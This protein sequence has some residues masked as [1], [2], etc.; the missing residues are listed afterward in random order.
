MAT[1]IRAL[2]RPVVDKSPG[3]TT[4]PFSRERPSTRA[5]K[6]E[7]NSAYRANE[8]LIQACLDGEES[9]WKELV[10][11][12]G[13]LVYSIPRR[14]G[15]SASDADDV[16]QNVF[17]IVLRSLGSLRNQTCLSAWLI[18]ITH[19]ETRRYARTAP[20]SL[21]LDEMLPDNS[22]P[23]VDKVQRLELQQS[24]R[25][26]LTELNPCC[27]EL[28]SSLL[29]DDAPSYEELA[30]RLGMAVGS[31]GPTRARCF[32]KLETILVEHGI[33]PNL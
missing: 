20:A 29:R 30:Q 27:R 26:A 19:R 15:L 21:E 7:A 18:T 28:I 22:S 5:P 3:S 24:V 23:A 4:R 6:Q 31:I 1:S 32:K 9:A 14:Y 10:E 33:D 17:S 12:Y 11:R 25:E 8:A 13:R 2:P 16:F